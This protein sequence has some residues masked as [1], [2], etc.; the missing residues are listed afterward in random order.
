MK[1]ADF[2][3]VDDVDGWLL[4]SLTSSGKVGHII[5]QIALI[6]HGYFV[7]TRHGDEAEVKFQRNALFD[8]HFV[9]RDTFNPIRLLV[10]NI[11]ST[12]MKNDGVLVLIKLPRRVY[13]N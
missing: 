8:F 3:S 12:I 7:L 5:K 6:W 10:R 11:K 13:G 1:P 9:Q 4:G 2:Q